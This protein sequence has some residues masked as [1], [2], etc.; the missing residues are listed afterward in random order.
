MQNINS[1]ITNPTVTERVG[2]EF[3]Y[4]TPA[5]ILQSEDLIKCASLIHIDK[6]DTMLL[7]VYE[8]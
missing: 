2:Q 7:C 4:S 6:V 5:G 1:A 8:I 3:E